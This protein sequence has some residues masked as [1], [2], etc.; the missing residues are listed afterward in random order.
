MDMENSR[1]IQT[2]MSGLILLG[3]E[4]IMQGNNQLINDQLLCSGY[5]GGFNPA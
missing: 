3:K 1:Y 2:I 4:W 5:K